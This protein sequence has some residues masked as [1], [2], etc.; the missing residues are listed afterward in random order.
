MSTP[1][2]GQSGSGQQPGSD[3]PADSDAT[4]VYRPGD[5]G[6]SGSGASGG[7]PPTGGPPGP[8]AGGTSGAASPGT[9]GDSYAPPTNVQ[10]SYGQP[11]AYGGQ[12]SYDPS[13][14]GQPGGSGGQQGYYQQPSY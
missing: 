12:T 9:M 6:V 2:G 10:P 4:T 1:P 7:P 13:S 11:P 14:Y 3:Q 5:Y 8:P